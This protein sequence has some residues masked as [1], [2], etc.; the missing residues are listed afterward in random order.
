[1]KCHRLVEQRLALGY[2]AALL[3]VGDVIF[4]VFVDHTQRNV[5]GDG[6]ADAGDVVDLAAVLVLARRLCFGN[7]KVL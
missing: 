7:L 2:W 3:G 1:M 6:V 4:F 5:P